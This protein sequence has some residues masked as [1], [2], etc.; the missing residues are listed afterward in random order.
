MSP[1]ATQILQHLARNPSGHAVAE[2]KT[3][4]EILL[5]TGGNTL[6]CGLLYDI[7]C[8]DIGAGVYRLSLELAGVAPPAA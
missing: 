6:A 2:R 8:K 3:A 1:E 5:Q 7:I 4:K